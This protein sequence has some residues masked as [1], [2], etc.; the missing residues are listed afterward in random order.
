MRVTHLDHVTVIVTDVERSRAFYRDVLGLRRGAAAVHLDF[1][2]LW[3]TSA[4]QYL[5]LFHSRRPTR[6]VRGTSPCMSRTSQ[7]GRSLPRA[8][9]RYRGDGKHSECRSLFRPRPGRQPHRAD[10]VVSSRRPRPCGK[11]WN[12]CTSPTAP[13]STDGLLTEAT[14]RAPATDPDRRPRPAAAGGEVIDLGGRY[15]APGFVTCTSTAGDGAE[16]HGSARRRSA[17]PAGHT[18]ATGPPVC[19]RPRP[20]PGTINC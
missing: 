15:L 12:R 7:P 8:R 10:P 6:S 5:H 16:L 2:V 18:P 17:P 3:S 19:C 20:S 1:V 11:R 13:S 14:S 4:G 9:P